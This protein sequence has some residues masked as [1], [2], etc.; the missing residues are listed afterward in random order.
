MEAIFFGSQKS[1]K[2]N[3]FQR[4]I[5]TPHRRGRGSRIGR[6]M[7]ARGGGHIRP[8]LR[9]MV[10]MTCSAAGCTTAF[11]PSG[12]L[13][14]HRA[15]ISG[16]CPQAPGGGL[17]VVAPG[18][19]AGQRAPR[20]SGVG[21]RLAMKDGES[22]RENAP[23]AAP[24]VTDIELVEL[25]R[26]F[27]SIDSMK[28]GKLGLREVDSVLDDLG[29]DEM[30]KVCVL[31]TLDFD[32]D[33]TVTEDEFFRACK[34]EGES[35]IVKN[36]PLQREQEIMSDFYQ[37]LIEYR[38]K[39]KQ[40]AREMAELSGRTWV[41]EDEAEETRLRQAAAAAQAKAAG[42]PLPG[43]VMVLDT[44][45]NFNAVVSKAGST[46]VVVKYFASWCRK[47]AALK[48]KYAQIARAYGDKAFFVKMDVESKEAK[49]FVKGRAGVKSIPT[50]QIWK[51]GDKIDQYVAGTS[52]P[53]V[54]R[55][56]ADMIDTNLECGFS[57][58]S[59]VD[60]GKPSSAGASDPTRAAS[61]GLVADDAENKPLINMDA[62]AKFREAQ[63]KSQSRKNPFK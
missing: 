31:D 54:P 2:D 10:L 61:R 36:A 13:A 7:G 14:W 32:G 22:C 17:C 30:E 62:L 38:R 5:S 19:G 53:Q 35:C 45:E 46:L 59:E 52:I 4:H 56:L 23:V 29:Y 12:P 47:C 9:L 27:R 3:R 26:A 25:Q 60:T 21:L 50:F 15:S 39:Q 49:P 51:N 42:L 1:T 43:D 16:V 55:K 57:L 44:E 20:E 11:S 24:L 28:T 6:E 34:G 40:R 8:L 37:R 41:D 18:A 33:G 63:A 48:P 58:V